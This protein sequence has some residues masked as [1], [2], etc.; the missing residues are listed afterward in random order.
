MPKIW[1][2]QNMEGQGPYQL[3]DDRG[4]VDIELADSSLIRHSKLNGHPAPMYDIGI[5]RGIHNKEICGFK[6]LS[7]AH[8]WFSE[9]ELEF[10]ERKGFYLKQIEVDEITAI[11]QYQVLAIKDSSEM[12]KL[13]F[14]YSL[15]A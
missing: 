12:L 9:A 7:Q 10:L 6:N 13:E 5:E 11:G 1:R 14:E 2:V 4:H 15:P 3:I 8:A